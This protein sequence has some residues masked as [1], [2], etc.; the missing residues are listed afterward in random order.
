[1]L[2]TKKLVK[3]DKVAIVSLSSGILGESSAKHELDLGIKRVKEMG[4]EPVLMPNSIKGAEYVKNHPEKRAED[5]KTAI[6]DKEIKAIICAIG[7]NDTHRT[8]P[9]LLGDKD[10]IKAVQ[11][12]PK[13]FLGYSDT[14]INHF[15]FYKLGLNTFY[16]IS[17][18]TDFAELSK[19]MLPYTKNAINYLFLNKDNFEIESSKVWYEERKSFGVSE[20]HRPLIAHNENYGYEVLK[21]SGK[22]C[23][24]LLGGC[25]ESIYSALDKTEEKSKYD[26]CKKY[27]LIPK[28]AEWQDKILFIE[29]CEEKP[30]PE[31]FRKEIL[32]LKKA[33]ILGAVKGIIIGKPQDEKY[34]LEYKKIILEETKRFNKPIFYNVNFGHANPRTILSIGVNCELDCDNK[35]ITIIEKALID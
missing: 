34:Y 26:I 27:K 14:T 15:M 5:L 30:A 7:G 2:K 23:G 20:L 35:K 4:L 6:L 28:K 10:F 16:G 11:D 17:F 24:K 25:L 33:G 9:F 18:L 13:I 29:T 31:L 19:D 1:M 12:N 22:V 3:G 8:L 21:G 32:A